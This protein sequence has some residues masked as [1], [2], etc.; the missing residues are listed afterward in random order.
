MALLQNKTIIM[1]K[2]FT[3]GFCKDIPRNATESRIIPF[4]ISTYTRDRH[5]TVLNQDNWKLENYLKNPVIFYQHNSTGLFT[6]PDPD[7]VIA[8][9]VRIYTE[10]SG[11]S[12]KLV[13]HAEFEPAESNQLAEKIF[14][15]VLFGSLRSSSVGFLEIGYGKYGEG[16]KARGAEKETYY[17]EG[18]ELLEWSVVNIPSN[19]DAGKRLLRTAPGQVI[20]YAAHYMA[21]YNLKPS[22]VE[23]MPVANIDLM[24]EALQ[25]GIK[26]PDLD[27]IK[28]ILT[29][30]ENRLNK[31]YM[32]KLQARMD[33]RKHAAALDKIKDIKRARIE[34]DRI[35][36]REKRTREKKEGPR[37]PSLLSDGIY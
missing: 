2:H 9:T 25:L 30:R 34:R 8:K 18:Q 6:D 7:F 16:D 10:G 22:K 15:K 20:E 11:K 3:R 37:S 17:F 4:V 19:P 35:V 33:E 13:A 21:E 32:L 5:H 28:D 24:I 29:E 14:R 1:K 27:K 12:K 23:N 26:E 31:L 36:F